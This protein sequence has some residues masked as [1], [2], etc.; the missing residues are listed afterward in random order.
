MVYWFFLLKVGLVS[1]GLVRGGVMED[2]CVLL[3]GSEGY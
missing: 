1:G 2:C 3:M